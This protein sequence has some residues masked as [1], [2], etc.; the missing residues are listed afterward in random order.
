M[1]KSRF[2]HNHSDEFK[3][4]AVKEDTVMKMAISIENN[5]LKHC[6]I[7]EKLQFLFY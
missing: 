3:K 7:C 1:L 5:V 2:G 4:G 6:A